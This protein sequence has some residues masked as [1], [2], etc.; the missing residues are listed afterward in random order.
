M[1]YKEVVTDGV[2]VIMLL[3]VVYQSINMIAVSEELKYAAGAAGSYLFIKHS[4][5]TL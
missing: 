5:N 1:E 3:A 2:A 4:P